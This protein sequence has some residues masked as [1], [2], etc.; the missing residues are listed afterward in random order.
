MCFQTNVT[1]NDLL[2]LT[3]SGKLQTDKPGPQVQITKRKR[4][5]L[6]YWLKQISAAASRFF[7]GEGEPTDCP[8]VKFIYVK[9]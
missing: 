7:S 5:S 1:I 3:I 8:H 4:K 6:L 9:G 2:T